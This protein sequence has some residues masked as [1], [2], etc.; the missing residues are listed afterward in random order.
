[1][2]DLNLRPL[3]PKPSA[4]PSC[5]NHRHHCTGATGQNITA[6]Q[7]KGQTFFHLKQLTAYYL[8]L[9]VKK[10]LKMRDRVMFQPMRK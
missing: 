5:A 3:G 4:L 7:A 1:M 9:L 2:Q 10:Q 6:A 8:N